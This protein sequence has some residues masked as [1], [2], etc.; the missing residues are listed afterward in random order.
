MVGRILRSADFVRVL[1]SPPR[2]RSTHFALHHLAAAPSA[3]DRVIKAGA[4]H[5]L[6]TSAAQSCPLPVDDTP[7]AT[8]NP[9]PTGR[10]LGTVVPKRHAKRAVTRNLIKRQ[11]RALMADQ[12]ASLAPGLWV[13]RLK[14]PFDARQFVSAAS[15]PL[16]TCARAELVTLMNRARDRAAADRT[17]SPAPPRA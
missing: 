15:A 6:S 4:A 11:I 17:P 5:K 13:L 1:A 7:S 2:A 16:R 12:G 14:A 9:A 10:W 8:L 3:A